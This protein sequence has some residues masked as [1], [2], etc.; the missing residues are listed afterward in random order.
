MSSSFCSSVH[1]L[2]HVHI[3]AMLCTV[4]RYK[5]IGVTCLY[6]KTWLDRFWSCG[7]HSTQHD[8]PHLCFSPLTPDTH[9][10][11]TAPHHPS[12]SL[13]RD[14]D[15]GANKSNAPF[16]YEGARREIQWECQ[17]WKGETYCTG[18]K[19]KIQGV[20][21]PVILFICTYV[22]EWAFPGQAAT[23][24]WDLCLSTPPPRQQ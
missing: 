4:H 6:S 1:L 8:P 16:S 24:L 2:V 23:Q 18:K 3:H 10:G 9:T 19:Q 21:W 11:I 13:F 22:L 7:C 5:H 14:G 20:M 15:D 17:T 12:I